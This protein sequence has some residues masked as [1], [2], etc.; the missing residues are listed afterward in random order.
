ST[1][2]NWRKGMGITPSSRDPRNREKLLRR[3]RDAISRMTFPSMK[4]QW[5][6][7]Q[8]SHLFEDPGT[9][10]EE[11]RRAAILQTI[12]RVN[13]KRVID[14]ASNAG[15]YSFFAARRGA[16]VL[17]LDYDEKAVER[18]YEYARGQ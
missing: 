15:L 13:P 17:S 18:L 1:L 11:P 3:E 5:G 9:L 2:R 10:A 8:K 14:L 4:T 7:Y 16:Q 6:N 12:E